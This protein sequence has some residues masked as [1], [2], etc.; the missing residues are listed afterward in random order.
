MKKYLSLFAVLALAFFINT[1]SLKAEDGAGILG[2]DVKLRTD[3]KA[4]VKSERA[5]V[6]ADMN[7]KVQASREEARLRMEALREKIQGEK[8]EMRAKAQEMRIVG[9]EKA[10]ERFDKIIENISNLKDRINAKISTLEEKGVDVTGAKGFIV[11]AETNLTAA[12]DKVTEINLLLAASIETLTLEDK[13]KLRTL[14][15]E[16]QGFIVEAHKALRDAIKSLKDAL[17]VKIQ[18]EAETEVDSN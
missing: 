18:A 17:R 1:S 10:L 7:L 14:T 16:A 11:E 2:T 8:D 3:L 5:E 4:E 12:K 6:R 15:Q 9:R 13:T